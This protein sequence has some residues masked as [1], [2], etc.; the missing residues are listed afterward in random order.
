[1]LAKS[2]ATVEVLSGMELAIM[3]PRFSK[4]LQL[5]E[6]QQKWLIATVHRQ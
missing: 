2:A 6:S 3:T 4:H 5:P 1:M